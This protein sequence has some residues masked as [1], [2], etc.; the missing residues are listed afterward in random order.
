MAAG[1]TQPYDGSDT[2]EHGYECH[3]PGRA[4]P[5][6]PPPGLADQRLRFVG[7]GVVDLNFVI[8]TQQQQ[9]NSQVPDEARDRRATAAAPDRLRLRRSVDARIA[10]TIG[11]RKT[12]VERIIGC[13][14][15]E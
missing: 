5:P 7:A 11:L 12:S 15:C 3:A 13:P 6:G 8:V 1:I 9:G 2:P 10:S 14:A 4:P